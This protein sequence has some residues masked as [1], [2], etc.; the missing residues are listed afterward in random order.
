MG[1]RWDRDGEEI[2]EIWGR[3]RGEM[4]ASWERWG[5]D[6]RVTSKKKLN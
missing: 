4:G 2:G 1:D 6:E 3:Y 5:R